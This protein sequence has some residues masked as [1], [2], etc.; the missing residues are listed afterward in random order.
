MRIGPVDSGGQPLQ[1]END[2]RRQ[3][4]ASEMNRAAARESGSAEDSIEISRQAWEMARQENESEA[5]DET[6]GQDKTVPT[7]NDEVKMDGQETDRSDKLD[8]IKER[9]VDGYYNRPEVKDKAARRIADD[10]MG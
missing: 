2:P 7:S 5:P 6:V 1:P 3:K 4:A 9:T 10:F 8:Q